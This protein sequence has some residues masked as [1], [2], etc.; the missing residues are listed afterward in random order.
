MDMNYPY[1]LLDALERAVEMYPENIALRCGNESWTYQEF[2]DRVVRAAA[3]L[4]RLGVG[5]GDRIAVLSD[6]C[7][8]F[9]ELYWVAARLG[10]ILVPLGTRLSEGEMG[11]ILHETS[12]TVLA[13]DSAE[14]HDLLQGLCPAASHH[15]GLRE[16]ASNGVSYEALV[17]EDHALSEGRPHA[18]DD[19]IVVF[20]TAATEG[21]PRGAVITHLNWLTQAVQTGARIGTGPDEVYG[22]FLPY[23]HAFEAYMTV[24]S[25]CHGA[26]NVIMPS[27]DAA[28]A[29]R[30][31]GEHGITYFTE[32]TPMA[33]RI[34][35][36]AEETGI[37]LSASLNRV[38]G[39]DLPTTIESYLERGIRWFTLYGQ[40]EVAGMA[41]MG[42]LEPGD[43]VQENYVGQPLALTRVSLRNAGGT[44]VARGESGEA[45]LRSGAVVERYWQDE[46]TRLTDDG[47]LRSGD[48]LRQDERGEFW[49]VGRTDDKALIKTG[50]ENVYPT[51][52]EQVLLQHPAILQAC[53]FGIPD[54]V[55]K[56]AVRAVVVL[57]KEQSL[58]PDDVR[59]FCEGRIAKFKW[60]RDVIT[61]EELPQA[62][63]QVD[64]DAV[65]QKYA[66]PEFP[67]NGG[68]GSITRNH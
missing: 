67:E 68:G 62:G 39:I 54:P 27:F 23:Y 16:K 41:A 32:F 28:E 44:P 66:N 30:L 35:E 4:D 6:N 24:V 7:H 48:L 57:N 59:S 49:F 12:P 14:R 3:G 21:R 63:E 13:A 25:L 8:R 64:R 53:V 45:W 43:E 42:K 58:T 18:L 31:I 2:H 26:T 9:A 47:W 50:G 36:A 56:E 34:M 38:V 5:P 46:P 15:V 33:E 20:Y 65:R 55:W 52:V 11:H 37:D 29:A 61:A 19:P 51:E 10:A 22:A 40:A 17:E 60:P 1:N